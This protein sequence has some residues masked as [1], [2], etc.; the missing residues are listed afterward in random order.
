MAT[1]LF[2][3]GWHAA[4]SGRSTARAS[5]PVLIF[6]VAGLDLRFITGC[7]RRG[8]CDRITLPGLRHHLSRSSALLFAGSD[9]AAVAAAAVLVLRPRPG[10]CCSSSSGFAARCRASA[11][12]S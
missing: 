10:S 5:C 1:L 11:T 6:V 12:T 9:A 3:G 7:I 4:V 8:R 2:L